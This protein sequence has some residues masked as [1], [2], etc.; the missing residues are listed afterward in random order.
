MFHSSLVPR[1][2]S[3]GTRLVPFSPCAMGRYIT[4]GSIWESY[5]LSPLL[6]FLCALSILHLVS[7][8]LCYIRGQRMLTT[9]ELCIV[10]Y[11][12]RPYHVN[13][14][15]L[16]VKYHW[17]LTQISWCISQSYP[18]LYQWM[19][20]P[21]CW[22]LS[23]Q[24]ILGGWSN[25]TPPQERTHRCSS[26]EGKSCADGVQYTTQRTVRITLISSNPFPKL[27]PILLLE[28]QTRPH[29]HLL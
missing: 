19:Y 23:S 18:I 25:K 11:N 13:M 20:V 14:L 15:T 2:R 12:T 21:S 27:F 4:G 10:Q 6:F 22:Q 29:A 7:M 17:K 28:L 8:I 3:L 1:P 16:R 9:S 26:A 24:R 5:T